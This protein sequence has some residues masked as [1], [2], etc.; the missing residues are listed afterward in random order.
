MMWVTII[1]LVYRD[2][3]A[4]MLKLLFL[5]NSNIPMDSKPCYGLGCKY[6]LIN[7]RSSSKKK[8]EV[9]SSINFDFATI[10]YVWTRALYIIFK[11]NL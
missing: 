11:N 7:I 9:F 3:L 4:F 10:A 2:K 8:I 5:L 1:M 6:P